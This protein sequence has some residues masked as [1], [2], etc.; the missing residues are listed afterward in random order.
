MRSGGP[1]YQMD[2]QMD[3]KLSVS[4][5]LP[6][7]LSI[8]TVAVGLWQFTA[9]EEHRN[10]EAFLKSQLDLCFKATES[11]A[12]LATETDP[13][14]WEKARKEFWQLYWGPLSV[15]EDPKV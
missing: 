5:I 4:V 12:S 11:A 9:Q 15:V 3:N 10:K 13:A 6:W 14:E 1:I 7:I 8:I 2:N